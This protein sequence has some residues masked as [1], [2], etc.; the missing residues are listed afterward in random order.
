MIAL[1][2]RLFICLQKL[3]HFSFFFNMFG[4][5][6]GDLSVVIFDNFIL[7]LASACHLKNPP[8]EDFKME[9]IY[10][11]RRL[12]STSRSVA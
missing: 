10:L 1:G 6:I 5:K 3:R 7:G 4:P 8:P 9:A 11:S 2:P 12:S